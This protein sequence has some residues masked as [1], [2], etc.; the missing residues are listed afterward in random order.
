MIVQFI[1]RTAMDQ[2]NHPI[3]VVRVVLQL[4]QLTLQKDINMDLALL[5]Y[6]I[7]LLTSLGSFIAFC[8]AASAISS[9][10]GIMI[11]LYH[12]LETP[13]DYDYKYGPGKEV[14]DQRWN[15]RKSFSKS[16]LKISV[17]A[18]FI[19]ATLGLLLPSEKTAYIMV[20]AYTAQRVAENPEVQKL[21]GKVLTIIE[22][23]LDTYVNEAEKK[24][25]EKTK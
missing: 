25:V 19:A 5:V 16:I 24:I 11:F 7:S 3:V 14:T 12:T 21:S 23:K 13:S 9:A 2:L 15:D 8:V 4:I 10:L 6:G 17:P 22:N 1:L 18:F 20:G